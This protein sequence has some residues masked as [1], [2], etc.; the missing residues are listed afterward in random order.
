M[1]AARSPHHATPCSPHRS[2]QPTPRD[3]TQ[4][5]PRDSNHRALAQ[6]RG[7]QAIGERDGTRGE[8]RQLAW[9]N[10]A[11]QIFDI[12]TAHMQLQ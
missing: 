7:R 1:T 10:T 12:T 11:D 3:T 6:Q 8:N 2:T 4:P 9:H 5:T